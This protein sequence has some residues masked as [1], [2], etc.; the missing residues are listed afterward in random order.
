VD[1]RIGTSLLDRWE[2]IKPT[3]ETYTFAVWH[4]TSA[5][6][7][8]VRWLKEGPGIIWCHHRFFAAALAERAGIAYFGADGQD[9]RGRLIDDRKV[10]N[11]ITDPKG[12]VASISSNS[13]G[14]NLQHEDQWARNLVA[15]PP[16]SALTW[17]QM[18]GRTHREGQAQDQVIVDMLV[19]CRE[20]WNAVTKALADAQATLE[21]TGLGQRL[22]LASI[23]DF[24][25]EDDIDTREAGVWGNCEKDPPDL[26]LD[27]LR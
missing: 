11:N 2:T 23:E 9:S 27:L 14:R 10:V 13:A 26:I 4:D 1:G 6:D 15:S 3:C 19:G 22:L 7:A 25:D 21:L 17:E 12:I 24:P 16:T 20:H 5:L 18:I 8:C